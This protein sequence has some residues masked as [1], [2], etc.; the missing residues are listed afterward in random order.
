[1][2]GTTYPNSIDGYIS[3]PLLVDNVS[4]VVADDHNRLRNTIVTIENELGT[5]PSS[6]YGT[7]KDRLDAIE[8]SIS[9]ISNNQNRIGAAEDGSY[10]DGLFTDFV[11]STPIGTAVDRFNEV[12]KE[13]APSPAPNLSNISYTTGLGT[14]GKVSF[15]ISNTISTYFNVTTADGDSAL[16]INGTVTS[17]ASLAV[18]KGIYA[19]G[20]VKQ[21][22]LASNVP[23]GAGSPTPA[24]PAKSIG[25]GDQGL[26]QLFVN[27]ALS[28]QVDL[29]T[30]GSG[31]SLNANGSGFIN[32]SSATSVSFP[33]G[34]PF[35]LFKY[36]TGEWIVTPQD[37]RNGHNYVQVKHVIGSNTYTTNM[38]GWVNDAD[39]TATT[40]SGENLYALAMTGSKFI[41]GVQYHTAGTASYDITVS[42]LHRNTYSSSAS[43]ISHGA[44]INVSIPSTALGS[45]ATQSDTEIITAKVATV[46]GT[47]LLNATITGKTSV[48]RTVQSDLTSTG[49][50]I[51]GILMDTVSDDATATNETLNGEK[52]RVPSNRSLTDTSGFTLS[53]ASLWI[54]TNNLITGP[55]GYND[56][57]LV[58]NGGLFY[59]NNAS[60]AN[61]GN[62]SAVA[63]GPGGNPNYSTASGTRTYWRY[64]YFSSATQNFVLNVTSSGCSFISTA[65]ALGLNN[66]NVHME[67][68]A[69]NT[70]SNGVSIE[71]KDCV[72]AYT[73]DNA[74]G[75]FA[76]TYG[77]TIPTNW[78]VTLGTKSTATSGNAIIL[79]VTVGNGWTGTISNIS[80]I[81]V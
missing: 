28:H 78:G 19:S 37:Q 27:G 59:P 57:L 43:A 40:F 62:F 45:I 72:T 30:F 29:S 52:F 49:A 63:N 36:R 13:L 14:A 68:L 54:S 4:P 5:N 75:C 16:D 11:S 41:S 10:T 48:D 38:F 65:S 56:G 60:V 64:F 74:I 76:A 35:S 2:T 33:S 6:T 69:P 55:A 73:T 22:E 50:S 46:T 3:L 25:N 15:G 61:N 31:S 42:N 12:L 21:G 44:S 1:M 23:A 70:T 39:V 80:L 81:G 79:R 71:F 8:A 32:L 67:L 9:G 77:P 26:L 34:A 17:A 53:G 18:R 51:T 66:G 47:R 58:Y 7:V 20:V 24:Y